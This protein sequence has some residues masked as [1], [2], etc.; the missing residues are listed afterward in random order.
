MLGAIGVTEKYPVEPGGTPKGRLYTAVGDAIVGTAV[1]VIGVGIGGQV[2]HVGHIGVTDGHPVKDR[3]SV[4]RITI[5]EV[6]TV[7]HPRRF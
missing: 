1:M 5:L 7:W 4:E 6:F 3:H 2:G